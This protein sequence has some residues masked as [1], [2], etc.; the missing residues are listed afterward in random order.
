MIQVHLDYTPK[1]SFFWRWHNAGEG[2]LCTLE[3]IY[4][5]AVQISTCQLQNLSLSFTMQN[6]DKLAL[7]DIMWLFAIQRR[8][9]CTTVEKHGRPLP[10]STNGKELQRNYR[11]N[12]K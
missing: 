4:F 12:S 6:N 11:I 7:L 1:E 10:F 2:M 8:L 5:A 9:T 3:A